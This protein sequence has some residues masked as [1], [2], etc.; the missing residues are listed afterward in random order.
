MVVDDVVVDGYEYDEDYRFPWM[1]KR[2]YRA[3]WVEELEKIDEERVF[4][5]MVSCG[6]RISTFVDFHYQNWM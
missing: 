2:K 5:M 1:M 3:T 4:A 6:K